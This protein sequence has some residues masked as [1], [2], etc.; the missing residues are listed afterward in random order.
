MRPRF[1]VMSALALGFVFAGSA[2]AAPPGPNVAPLPVVGI[3][4]ED[5]HE[6]AAALTQALRSSVRASQ[7]WSLPEREY[8]LEVLSLT[9]GC[10]EVPD[11]ACQ[12]R[13]AD[14]IQ[15]E[16]YVWGTMQRVPGSSDV[17]VDLHLFE[18]ELPSGTLQLRYADNLVEGGDE[19]LK[20]LA[21]SAIQK[22]T[23]GAPR[24][25]VQLKAVS[26]TGEI[27]VDGQAFG[28]LEDGGA[29]LRLAPGEHQVEVR[30]DAGVETGT[31]VV[32][33]NET[34]QLVLGSN[35]T[36]LPYIEPE[37]RSRSDW[38]P[39]A[40][41]IGVGVGGGLVLGGVIS[42]LQV[43]SLQDDF[44]Y[45]QYRMGFSSS[46]NVCDAARDGRRATVPG[47][48]TPR[49][50]NE[51]C[52]KADTYTTLQYVFFGTGIAAIGVGAYFL[53]SAALDDGAEIK[54]GAKAGDMALL[55]SMG[56]SG[57]ALDF[58]LTF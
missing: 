52:D 4:S 22:L 23:G 35:R 50:V 13:I 57:G 45:Q 7:G 55:P 41:W 31:I 2:H 29:L 27:F 42:A 48:A 39:T 17:I 58:H 19:V 14:E 56:P 34:V 36:I 40:G 28:S 21:A 32:R 8:S 53:V 46:E 15:A 37:H 10:G 5:A 30:G 25:T 38:R 3:S 1:V 33:P 18:R 26:A 6:Q 43:S 20:Q 49:A 16:R 24:G 12:L 47:A 51:I 9:L 11:A 54:T 44:G